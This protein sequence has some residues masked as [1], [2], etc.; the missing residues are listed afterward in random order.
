[1]KGSNG[2]TSG[3]AVDSTSICYSSYS[4][5]GDAVDSTSMCYSLSGD[6]VVT[7]AALV[8]V[9]ACLEML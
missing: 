1:M 7:G 2:S 3:D 4:L 8:C 6:A 9:T 5:S